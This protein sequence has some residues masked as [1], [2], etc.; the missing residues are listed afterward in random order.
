MV[1]DRDVIPGGGFAVD[2]EE[3]R[4]AARRIEHAADTAAAALHRSIDGFCSDR[5]P[6]QPGWLAEVDAAWR[7]R[8][9][10]LLTALRDDA[11]ALN[12][13][14]TAY[15]ST[16]HQLATGIGAGIGAAATR[17]VDRGGAATP[18]TGYPSAPSWGAATSSSEHVDLVRRWEDRATT[19]HA[20]AA[21]LRS[22]NVAT[23]AWWGHAATA[24]GDAIQR[25]A[26]AWQE[27]HADAERIAAVLR[28]D[29]HGADVARRHPDPPARL[30]RDPHPTVTILGSGAVPDPGRV[31]VRDTAAAQ[32]A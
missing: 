11:Q 27:L 12:S 19:A 4:Y 32:L 28:R 15:T 10:R 9:H 24:Y 3:L 22:G 14:H 13:T 16:D 5:H 20:V 2:P 21:I 8:S 23:P 7:D 6:R 18:P 29:L 1:G 17:V 30:A 31:P 25:R 26:Q